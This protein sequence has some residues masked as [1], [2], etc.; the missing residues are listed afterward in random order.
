MDRDMDAIRKIV[1]ALKESKTVINK[2]DGVSDD[3]FKFNAMLLIE[4]GIVTG[5]TKPGGGRDG[6]VI[7]SAALL[8]RLTWAGCDFADSIK[9]DVLW[10][11]AKK[12]ILIPFGSW[13]F[14]V[15]CKYLK[16]EIEARLG[17]DGAP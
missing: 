16:Q 12:H 4:A 9:D 11:K 1:L 15:L 8:F 7:P 14:S 2:V 6:S 10:A 5:T 13:T 17:L 3:V